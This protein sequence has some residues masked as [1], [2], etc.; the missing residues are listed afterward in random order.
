MATREIDIKE[1]IVTIK[2][3]GIGGGGN[4]VL[5]RLAESN[6]FNTQLIAINTD[7]RQLQAVSRFG[8]DTLLIGEH[9]TN[10]LGTGG[11]VEL[12]QRAALDAE[13]Q[14]R[15]AMYGADMVFI[16]AAMGGGAGTGAA[17]VVARIA[18]EMGLLTIGV[19]T[20]PFSFEGSRK[21]RTAQAGISEMQQQLDALLIVKNDNLLKLS[22]KKLNMKEAF[23]LADE[24]MRQAI[25][26]IVEIIQ[27]TGVINV[28][29]ADAVTVLRQGDSSD[30][31]LGTGEAYTAMDAVRAAINNP[32]ID[33]SIA[34]ARG[35]VVNITSS[36]GIPIYDV[37]EATQFLYE[38][39][40]EDVNIIWG[41]VEDASMG[42]RVRATIVATDFI[43][44]TSNQ[45]HNSPI[46]PMRKDIGNTSTADNTRQG[47][48]S[49]IGGSSQGPQQP[50]S[51]PIKP[52]KEI[53]LPEFMRR[54]F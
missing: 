27:T 17:P 14:I 31:V 46:P 41:I 34:G 47:T 3:F 1:A 39:S 52:L 24:T 42:D 22:N 29:F 4:N 23:Q 35:I 16:T 44:S 25:S 49:N 53:V 7:Y 8:V 36:A 19:V 50:L 13:E 32:L 48:S 54:K 21:M 18:R 33:R 11:K 15:Q 6:Q 5:A 9:L 37:G 26:C 20:T 12:G 28:D 40:H 51:S 30:A 45:V 38:S 10:R 43:D 2:I